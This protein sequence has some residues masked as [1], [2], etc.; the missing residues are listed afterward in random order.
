M[1]EGDR[2]ATK[3]LSINTSLAQNLVDIRAVTAYFLREPCCRP[4]L[5]TEF[6]ANQRPDVNPNAT[7]FSRS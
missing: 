3:Q 1:V 6:I 2:N 7:F 4:A 5:P